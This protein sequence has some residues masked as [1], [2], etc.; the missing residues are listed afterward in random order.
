MIRAALVC[1]LL[2]IT[3][4]IAAADGEPLADALKAA[5]TRNSPVLLD[6]HAP[7]CY[8]CY[9][10]KKNVLNGPEWEKLERDV[11]VVE[12]DADSPEGAAIKTQYEVKALPSYVV[13]NAQGL[14]LGRISAERTR[15]QFYPEL[16]AITSRNTALLVLRGR[17]ERGG[18]KGI[19]AINEV[20]FSH[21]AR[22]DGAAGLAWFAALP[23]A[24]HAEAEKDPAVIR[25][26]ARLT[27]KQAVTDKNANACFAAAR[28]ALSGKLDCNS[29]YDIDAVLQCTA[30]APVA[31]RRAFLATQRLAFET[32]LKDRVLNKDPSCADVRTSVFAAADFYEALGDAKQEKAVMLRAI[33]ALEPRVLQDLTADRNAADN[34]RV[35]YEAAGQDAKLDSLYLK[36]IAAYPDDYVYPSRYAKFLAAHDQHEQAL[37]YF[38]QAATRAYGVNRLKN[39]EARAKSLLALKRN[40]EAKAIVRE[41]L[42]ANGPWFPED[43]TRLRL[44]V[45]SS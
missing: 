37:P 4:P 30:A 45:A 5:Q 19:D 31:R 32:L 6:F 39:A 41:A 26:L 40:D 33:A 35:Y 14:E 36:L 25:K 20:L 38:E 29:A 13:L 18:A 11:V 15:A 28:E 34:L 42:K 12:L 1:L 17:A 27:L 8:S 2:V 7:W 9:Y 21:L 23:E 3:A 43:A 44:L 24:V 16:A 22:N 10:M